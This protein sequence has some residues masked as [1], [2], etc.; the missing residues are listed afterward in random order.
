MQFGKGTCKRARAPYL[1]RAASLTRLLID[2][3]PASANG[4]GTNPEELIAAAHAGCFTMATSFALQNAGFTATK[5]ETRA[6]LTL[7]QAAGGFTITGIHLT[8]RASVPGVS[9]EKF[10]EIAADAKANCP[11]SKVLS[12]PITLDAALV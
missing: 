3:K 11:V 2:S 7:E 6:D 8:V 12:C 10:Q 4:V 1:L 9:A 5:L